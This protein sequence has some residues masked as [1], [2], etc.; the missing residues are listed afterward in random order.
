MP[1]L[2]SHGWRE[3]HLGWGQISGEHDTDT[4]NILNQKCQVQST[5]SPDTRLE[6]TREL[7]QLSNHPHNAL[8]HSFQIFLL[9]LNNREIM[10][11]SKETT[12]YAKIVVLRSREDLE[13]DEIVMRPSIK[14]SAPLHC[15]CCYRG[16]EYTGAETDC[17]SA[18]TILIL[19]RFKL[20]L[21]T[22]NHQHVIFELNDP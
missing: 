19:K 14:H 10:K 16:Q 6:R 11:E 5:L 22:A 17:S 2:H 1:Q 3:S 4:D 20:V 9:N 12:R 18:A 21:I 13:S 15:R 8:K 7:S